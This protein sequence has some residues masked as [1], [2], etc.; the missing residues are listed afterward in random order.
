[1]AACGDD[2]R[3][4]VPIPIRIAGQAV[5]AGD[6]AFRVLDLYALVGYDPG[7]TDMPETLRPATVS[8]L[9][10]ALSFALRFDGRKRVHTGDEFM[11]RITAERLV[12]HLELSGFV[13]M[14]RPLAKA[15]RS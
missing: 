15:H 9:A 14:K 1:M 6:N 2:D 5:T 13:I 8:E 12:A 11:A 10:E 3:G 4:L 7:M